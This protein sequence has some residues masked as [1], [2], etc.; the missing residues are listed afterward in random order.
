MF[1]K[2]QELGSRTSFFYLGNVIVIGI[3]GLMAA[4]ILKIKNHL[5]PWQNLFLIEGCVAILCSVIFAL[6]LPD[7]PQHPFP[8]LFKRLSP[9]SARERE[10]IYARIILDD[11]QKMG[12]R[13]PLTRAEIVDTLTNWR[14]YPHILHIVACVSASSGMTQYAPLLIKSFGFDTIRAN[15][16]SSVGG[17]IAVVV[18]ASSGLLSDRLKN[19]GPLV[20]ALTSCSLIMWI[21]CE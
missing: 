16:L 11:P 20:I 14:N 7:S 3:G 15:A 10:I 13:Q 5:R 9:F 21:A 8:L 1:Y 4:G 19:K 18:M 2:R 17:W 6:V 12:P